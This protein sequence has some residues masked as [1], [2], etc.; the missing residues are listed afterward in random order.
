VGRIFIAHFFYSM[1]L[2]EIE[3]Y[4][5]EAVNT[6]VTEAGAEIYRFSVK[7]TSN[8]FAITLLADTDKGITLK[9][10]AGINKRISGILDTKPG[11]FG[12]YSLEVSSP[13]IDRLLSGKRDFLKIVG[14]RADIWLRRG[15][16]GP[17]FIN[18]IVKKADDAGIE[19]EQSN[20]GLISLPYDMINKA[21]RSFDLA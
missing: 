5:Q 3:E 18:G 17:D 20:G 4:A 13:G 21:K 2:K 7:K 10:C 8:G 6:A 9:E 12:R 1:D 11:V 14:S 16:P 15:S 19:I